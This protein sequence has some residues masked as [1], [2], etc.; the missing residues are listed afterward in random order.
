MES[1]G[2]GGSVLLIYCAQC[3]CGV[4]YSETDQLL[5]MTSARD[6]SRSLTSGLEGNGLEFLRCC[7]GERIQSHVQK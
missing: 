4:K 5:S 6:S 7:M 3:V 2:I 1:T